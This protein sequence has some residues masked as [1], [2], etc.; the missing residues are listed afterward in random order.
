MGFKRGGNPD[1]NQKA[2]VD[3]YRSLGASVEILSGVGHGCPDILVGIC[4]QTI[5]VEIKTEK[6]KLRPEQL[7]WHGTWRGARPVIIRSVQDAIGHIMY[8]RRKLDA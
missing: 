3:A 5:L 6:G 2:I 8:E 4:G 7:K 1:A